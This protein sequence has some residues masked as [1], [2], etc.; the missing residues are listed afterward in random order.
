MEFRVTSH[1]DDKLSSDRTW[2]LM[3]ISYIHL[4]KC[5]SIW[6]FIHRPSFLDFPLHQFIF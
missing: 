5:S 4:A 2:N 6:P 1:S 3:F